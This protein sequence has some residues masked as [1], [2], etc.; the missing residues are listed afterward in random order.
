MLKVGYD[1]DLQ[2]LDYVFVFFDVGSVLIE[3]VDI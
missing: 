1:L 2:F 3:V